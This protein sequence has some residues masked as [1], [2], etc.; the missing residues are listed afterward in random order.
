M[1]TIWDT[2]RHD[3]YIGL[4]PWA[5]V[6][7]ESGEPPG[8]LPFL[9]GVAPEVLA[10]LHEAHSVLLSGV[11]TAISDVFSRRASLADPSR[12]RLLEDAY[13]ELVNSRPHLSQHIMCKRQSDGTF[14]W[15]YP[16]DQTKSAT[17]TNMGLRVFNA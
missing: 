11:E 3:H 12:R 16:K 10:S 4:V 2:L 8:P 9:G 13:A 1:A 17:M 7:F 6:Q 15:E 5:W 14:L